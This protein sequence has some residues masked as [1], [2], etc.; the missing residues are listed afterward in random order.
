MQEEQE[1]ESLSLVILFIGVR[2][3]EKDVEVDEEL[4]EDEKEG[5]LKRLLPG[6]EVSTE[7]WSADFAAIARVTTMTGRCLPGLTMRVT[8]Q[9]M[10]NIK[11]T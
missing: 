2:G 9:Q 11:H 7:E 3:V 8:V 1:K 4:D 10:K 5:Y 6:E